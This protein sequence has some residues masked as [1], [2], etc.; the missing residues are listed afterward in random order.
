MTMPVASGPAAPARGRHDMFADKA[1]PE[2]RQFV[3]W[4]QSV[5]DENKRIAGL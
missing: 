5:I 2:N 1:M 3:H 4:M